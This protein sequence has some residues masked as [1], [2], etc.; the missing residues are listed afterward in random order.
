MLDLSVIIVSWNV[1]QLLRACLRSLQTS[2]GI[3]ICPPAALPDA[4]GA[5]TME[6]I[7]V[8]NASHDGSAEMVAADFPWVHLIASECNLGFTGGNNLGL[9]SSSRGRSV[10]FLNPDTEV[11][12]GAL[13]TMTQHLQS[14]AEIGILGPQLRYADGSLQSSRRRFPGLLTALF[15]STPLAWHWPDNPLAR[16]YHMADQAPDRPQQVDWIVGAAMLVRRSVRR[17]L[18]YVFRGTRSLP[19]RGRR[20][21]AHSLP[22][23]GASHPPRGEV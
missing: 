22:P 6:V 15:E 20:R 13:Q 14:H 19:P 1:Q 9:A 5:L 11:V 8:D 4:D 21:M 10:L 23:F 17:R 3:S 2:P 7:V 12:G 16:R 18:L